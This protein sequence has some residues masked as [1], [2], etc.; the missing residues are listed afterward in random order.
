MASPL[1][2]HF[3]EIVGGV[4][5]ELGAFRPDDGRGEALERDALDG[6]LISCLR[7]AA[8]IYANWADSEK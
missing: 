2:S 4:E 3:P 8:Q 7:I 6:S 1:R 5:C